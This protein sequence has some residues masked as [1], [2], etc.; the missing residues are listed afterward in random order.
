MDNFHHAID[1]LPL[2]MPVGI[3]LLL[4]FIF[5][6]LQF[7]LFVRN[8]FNKSHTPLSKF[9]SHLEAILGFLFL[10]KPYS[11]IAYMLPG[12]KKIAVFRNFIYRNY[13]TFSVVTL[14]GSMISIAIFFYEDSIFLSLITPALFAFLLSLFWRTFFEIQRWKEN[15]NIKKNQF[16]S[17]I[18][19]SSNEEKFNY[20]TTFLEYD[21]SSFGLEL[22]ELN[23]MVLNEIKE[24]IPE[25][26]LY[27]ITNLEE[28]YQKNVDK[29]WFLERFLKKKNN[30]NWLKKSLSWIFPTVVLFSEKY[31]DRINSV[32]R[33]Q[34]DELK[35]T[36][37]ADK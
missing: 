35:S 37:Y 5:L 11:A 15:I 20:L 19:I 31:A 6:A 3:P 2:Q 18:T 14:G 4:G 27:R 9:S 10:A 30:L 16:L 28:F 32:F 23:S 36:I 25:S 8:S 7:V 24:T 26:E 33:E 13:I 34:I 1:L 12:V 22:V 21:H 17:R 29:Y